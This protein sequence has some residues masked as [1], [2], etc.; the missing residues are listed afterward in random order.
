MPVWRFTQSS[1]VRTSDQDGSS[2]SLMHLDVGE[3]DLTYHIHVPV[4]SVQSH[5]PS[6]EL[7]TCTGHAA[8]VSHQR[9]SVTGKSD[10]VGLSPD[11]LIYLSLQHFQRVFLGRCSFVKMS[12]T[13]VRSLEVLIFFIRRD[14]APPLLGSNHGMASL[15]FLWSYADNFGVLARGA[16]CI[17]VRLARVIAGAKRNLP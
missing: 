1:P 3:V 13:T 14:S 7:S 8:V 9:S 16:N 15:G 5:A 2:T 4:E 6:D 10:C 11:S 12:R 17:N